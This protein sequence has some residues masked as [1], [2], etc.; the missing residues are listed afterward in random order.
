MDGEAARDRRWL[1]HWPEGI[2]KTVA[3]YRANRDRARNVA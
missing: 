3:W 1:D 2:A